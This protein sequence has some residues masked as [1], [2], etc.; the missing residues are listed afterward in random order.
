[1]SS[2]SLV[3]ITALPCFAAARATAA[4]TASG[5]FFGGSSASPGRPGQAWQTSEA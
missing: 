4:S 2:G 3:K 1:M 5:R